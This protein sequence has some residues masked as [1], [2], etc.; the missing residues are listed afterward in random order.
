MISYISL[1]DYAGYGLVVN[2]ASI[3]AITGPGQGTYIY[4]SSGAELRVC[5]DVTTIL[6]KLK[7]EVTHI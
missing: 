7:N 4:L 5:E 1:T 6:A 2:V 3:E